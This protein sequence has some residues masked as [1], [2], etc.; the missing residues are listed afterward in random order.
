MGAHASKTAR[1]TMSENAAKAYEILKK[2]EG[3][4]EGA[5]EWLEIDQS[6]FD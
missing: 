6:R 1:N 2:D 5:G 3:K 4:D